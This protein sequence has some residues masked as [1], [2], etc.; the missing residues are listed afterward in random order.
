MRY[1]NRHFQYKTV[2]ANVKRK[3]LLTSLKSHL[4]D[5]RNMLLREKAYENLMIYSLE[6]KWTFLGLFPGK[7]L[8]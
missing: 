7:F 2:K 3:N 5:L 1:Q 4:A 6:Y 8:I